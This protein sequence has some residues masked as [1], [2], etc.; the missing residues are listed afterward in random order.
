M[1]AY[2]LL[3]QN[4]GYLMIIKVISEGFYTKEE[5][6]MLTRMNATIAI[7]SIYRVRFQKLMV[8]TG[9]LLRAISVMEINGINEMIKSIIK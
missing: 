7:R 6:T 8:F 1:T 2:F 9:G 4:R 3:P 5:K